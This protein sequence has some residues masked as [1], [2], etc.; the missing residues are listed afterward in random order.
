[1]ENQNL[2]KKKQIKDR[3]KEVF[4]LGIFT[5]LVALASTIIMDI[6]IYPLS[7]F[8]INNKP[9]YNFIIKDILK[10]LLIFFLLFLIIRKV[11]H[12][13][14]NGLSNIEISKYLLQRPLYYTSTLMVIILASTIVILFIFFILNNNYFLLYKI[15]NG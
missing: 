9:L 12:L 1:M 10:Y 8:A 5:V 13:K 11:R 4:T 3:A 14:I 2:Y 6:I 15:T 7:V